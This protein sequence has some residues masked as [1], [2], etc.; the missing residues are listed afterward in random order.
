M[1]LYAS[2]KTCYGKQLGGGTWK[3]LQGK[4]ASKFP[5]SKLAAIFD[6]QNERDRAFNFIG[7]NLHLPDGIYWTGHTAEDLPGNGFY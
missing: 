7:A 6:Q 4:C 1:G 2:T 5:R 3:A